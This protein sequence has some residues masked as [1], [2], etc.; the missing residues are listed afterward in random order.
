[1]KTIGARNTYQRLPWINSPPWQNY[2]P[3]AW[4][5]FKMRSG[6]L[7]GMLKVTAI[8]PE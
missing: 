1:M 7:N 3:V 6:D 4:I 5:I 2:G 8:Y